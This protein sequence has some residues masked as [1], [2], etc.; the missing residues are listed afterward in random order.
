MSLCVAQIG[1]A[2]SDA[3]NGWFDDGHVVVAFDG[4]VYN[5]DE[6]DALETMSDAAVLAALYR[7]YGMPGALHRLNADFAC[8][9]F[10]RAQRRLYLA[11]DR[12]GVKPMYYVA[13]GAL[14]AFASRLAGLFCLPGVDLAPRPD[15]LATMAAGHYRFFDNPPEAT[16]YRGLAQLA[17]GM[18]LTIANGSASLSRWY[19]LEDQGDDPRSF[20][21]LTEAYRVLFFDS[22]KRRLARVDRPAFSLSGGLDSSSV[23][24]SA[25]L[26]SGTPSR[27]YSTVYDG[28]AYD[29]TAEIRDVLEGGRI[30]WQPIELGTF[31]LFAEVARLTARHDQPLSTVTWLAHAV[32]CEKIKASGHGGIL[33]GLGGDE[34]HAGEYDYFFYFFADLKAAGD[35]ARLAHE[36]A[37]WQRHHDHPVWRKTPGVAA[38]KMA[39]LTDCSVPGRV[40]ADVD[41]LAR[42]QEALSPDARSA[43][44]PT[45]EN[46]FQ[47]Y[48]KSHAYNEIYRETMPCCLR[49]SER[50]TEA[51]GL[52]DAF[53]FFD[54]RL[55]E[56]AFRV[57]SVLKIRDGVTKQLLR[58]AMKGTLPEKTRTRI[59]KTGWNAP[60]HQWLAARYK[61]PLLDL[62]RSRAFRERGLYRANVVEHLIEEHATIVESGAP[63]DNHMMFLWQLIGLELWLN[64]L[65]QARKA[66]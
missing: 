4:L 66:A 29:E 63:R 27:A 14:V 19:A 9:L 42:Y 8:A 38:M 51:L 34:Q 48:L 61:A 35:E 62:V 32:L 21:D 56:L 25:A 50:N 22:V 53:P 47:S 39:R 18:V 59:A 33:G 41:L 36:I 28:A 64:G 43:V 2:S 26:I 23:A 55:V 31:D 30:E 13:S 3:K 15:Y 16:P 57:P 5:R 49:A 24:T 1:L 12:F 58:T 45:L 40:I 52:T 7:R 65:A 10:D 44:A 17:P 20:Q 37:C 60:L 54:H 46:P 6:F 11:R